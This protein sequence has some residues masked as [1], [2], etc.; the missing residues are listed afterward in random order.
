MGIYLD[1][2]T[3]Q[4]QLRNTIMTGN[5]NYGFFQN[6]YCD[7]ITFFNST[8]NENQDGLGMSSGNDVNI[9]QCKFQYNSHNG[10]SLIDGDK[11]SI[12]N[13]KINYNDY[14]GIE[15][16]SAELYLE[17]C[18]LVDNTRP[19]SI[20][21][22]S[23]VYLINSTYDSTLAFESDYGLVY[24]GWFLDIEVLTTSS[25]PVPNADVNLISETE[26]VIV[27]PFDSGSSASDLV[28][29]TEQHFITD[30]TGMVRQIICYQK[31][32]RATDTFDYNP[33]RI[34]V[35]KD[36]IG[37]A[38]KT[39]HIAQ[40]TK[41]TLVLENYD[42]ILSEIRINKPTNK[43]PTEEFFNLT[44]EIKNTGNQPVEKIAIYY[45]IVGNEYNFSDTYIIPSISAQSTMDV[46]LGEL[47]IM[48]ETGVYT[49]K[50]IIDYHDIIYETNE[51]NNEYNFE[52][53]II[54]RPKAV[55]IVNRS[56]AYVGENITFD[57]SQSSG[58][59]AILEYIF[60]FGD[61]SVQRE[62]DNN[63]V[64]HNYTT[65]STYE[66]RLHVIDIDGISSG[67]V[68]R[69]IEVKERPELPKPPEAFFSITPTT[70]D[71]RTIFRFR[72]YST[73]STDAKI[74]SYHWDFGD[75]K[76]STILG[77][78]HIYSDDRTYEVK[79]IIKD[80]G[81]Q[82]A[83]YKLKLTVVNV[84]PIIDLIVENDNLTVG[85]S[86]IFNAS[87]T[88]DLDDTLTE[89]LTRFIW[90]FGDGTNYTESPIRYPDG[91]F[92]K[93][94]KHVYTEPGKYEV[95]LIVYD[96][97]GATNQTSIEVSVN[98][99][100]DQLKPDDGGTQEAD[101]G[102]MLGALF[103]FLLILLIIFLLFRR[104][105][106]DR[107]AQ[108]R[109]AKLANDLYSTSG[110]YSDNLDAEPSL[111]GG[112]PVGRAGE[113]P[114][115]AEPGIEP[116]Y[117]KLSDSAKKQKKSKR[118]RVGAVSRTG[119]VRPVEVEVE[120]PEE[121]VVD[122]R[123]DKADAS[124]HKLSLGDVDLVTN[125]DLS[126]ASIIGIGDDEYV[127]Y[128]P[129]EELGELEELE[130][131]EAPEPEDVELVFEV[132]TDELEEEF[133]EE[134]EELPEGES[135]KAE[136]L[137]DT[138]VFEFEDDGITRSTEFQTDQKPKPKPKKKDDLIAIPGIGFVTRDE[139]KRAIGESDEDF[140]PGDYSSYEIP[141]PDGIPLK[142]DESFFPE[143]ELRCKWCNKPIKGKYIK[144]R[145]KQDDDVKFGIVGPF[146]SPEC[147]KK[148]GY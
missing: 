29:L 59:V 65:P 5:G 75:N 125:G 64:E 110:E 49:V 19:M 80:S 13:S 92:D 74:T 86:V 83:E 87:Q 136:P 28:D 7:N 53:M 36:G 31:I 145:R 88:T 6:G 106:R 25:T 43:V 127:E 89:P 97:D 8:F 140:D 142:V 143:Q 57:A 16:N 52:F 98:E 119:S 54:E 18:S 91:K 138:L 24:V 115:L 123:G 77:P 78:S 39:V 96:D 44:A 55:L 42:L 40:S 66:A 30:P 45:Q 121:K 94:T 38:T 100:F 133:E 117:T 35:H 76:T 33:Y 118:K 17:N 73:P 15:T 122:W 93:N 20:Y 132:D 69:L 144:V 137:E 11:F 2:F 139:L 85:E 114:S 23:I 67:M 99:A 147:A 34:S 146:C 22:N 71:I 116:A 56:V 60:E 4:F 101:L 141:I 32:V 105:R 48:I 63:I 10:L 41:I 61:G 26:D 46:S 104:H 70:G 12:Y 129:V 109:K 47:Y 27:I 103:I 111:V 130:E 1:Y 126:Q 51:M 72:S 9:Y 90:F 68:S 113:V 107:Q 50:A 95:T 135:D 37:A 120:L 108:D 58:R 134:F 124:D 62:K 148:F 3:S 84:E 79:L 128:Q 81:G 102:L 21:S 14:Y 131:L 82:E 112:G